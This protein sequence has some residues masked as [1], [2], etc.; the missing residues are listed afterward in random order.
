M[1]SVEGAGPALV[2]TTASMLAEIETNTAAEVRVHH[3]R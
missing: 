1:M 2:R 3:G